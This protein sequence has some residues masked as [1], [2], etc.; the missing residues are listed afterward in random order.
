[1]RSLE[2]ISSAIS[3]AGGKPVL[4]GGCVRDR[5]M[6]R[7]SKDFDIEVYGLD[8]GSLESVLNQLGS[9]HAVGKSFGVFKLFNFDISLPRTENKQGAGHKGFVVQSDPSLTFEQASKRR[10][11]T[12]NAMGIDLATGELLDPHGGQN[13]LKTLTLK[14]VSDAFDEDPLRVLRAC[15]F[16]ARLE[17]SIHPDTLTKCHNLLPELKTLPKERIGEEFKKLLMANKPSIGLQALLDTRALGL[18]PELEALIGCQQDPKWHPEGDVWI[19]T[20]MVV[21]QA[22]RISDQLLIRLGAL[23]HDL[24]KPPTTKFE[25][26]RWRSKNHEAAGVPPTQQ[27][28]QR[29]AI[30][31][32]LINEITPL[33]QDHLKPCQLYNVRDQVSDAAIKRL[34][35]RVNIENLCL[36]AEADFLGRT[37]EEAL[38][39]HDP[40]TAWLREQAA[41]LAVT[42]KPLEA[43]LQGRHLL[44]LGMHAGPA[45]GRL[46]KKAYEAQIEGEFETL[47]DALDWV[48]QHH[49]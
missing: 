5:L 31:Q 32:D 38:A 28:L 45:M 21:D 37:T 7:D 36:V 26:G 17:F 12:V 8:L 18:F 29:L 43:L 33:V 13:D 1:M 2:D 14:H 10:D 23:C 49:A 41:R 3:Q 15:Q 22:A 34:A 25:D 16:A 11:F 24:G 30:A 6:G 46:L 47:E 44:D 40:S 19:H 4:V 35:T 20:L 27:F 48:K 9:V 39:G 42:N